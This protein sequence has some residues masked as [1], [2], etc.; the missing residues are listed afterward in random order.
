MTL[1]RQKASE[2]K[3]VGKSSDFSFMY[4]NYDLVGRR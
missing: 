3:A 2:E 4:V 1:C